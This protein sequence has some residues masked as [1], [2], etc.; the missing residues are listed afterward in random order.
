MTKNPRFYVVDDNYIPVRSN[1]EYGYTLQGAIAQAVGEAR[2]SSEILNLPF[3]VTSKWFHICD[4]NFHVYPEFD[5]Y[6]TE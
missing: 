2:C 4:A 3:S 6:I 1:L 5:E